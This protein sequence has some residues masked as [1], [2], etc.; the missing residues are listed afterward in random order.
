MR[1]GFVVSHFGARW[2]SRARATNSTL[3]VG[4]R[5][6]GLRRRPS[7]HFFRWAEGSFEVVQWRARLELGLFVLAGNEQAQDWLRRSCIIIVAEPALWP[8]ENVD[9][10]Q[11]DQQKPKDRAAHRHCSNPS[12]TQSTIVIF[13]L[14][15]SGGLS[16][17]RADQVGPLPSAIETLDAFS[18][19]STRQ[20][21]GKPSAGGRGCRNR[22]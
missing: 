1:S 14:I 19:R 6:S 9:E 11:H 20:K 22:S 13:L 4:W 15:A 8:P 12:V 17:V 2:P 10:G 5:R 16:R 3:F 7:V 18:Q 21:G